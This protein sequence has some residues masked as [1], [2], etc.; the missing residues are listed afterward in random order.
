MLAIDEDATG[1]EQ[2][3]NRVG[4]GVCAVSPEGRVLFWNRAAERILGYAGRE[5][6]GRPC[7]DVFAGHDEHGNRICHAGCHVMTLVRMQEPVQHFDMLTRARDGRA[8]WLDVSIVALPQATAGHAVAGG[9]VLLHIFR[10][11]TAARELLDVVRARHGQ[12]SLDAPSGTAAPLTRREI[13]ILRLVAQGAPTK[14][15]AEKLHVSPAT[16]RN[17]VQNIL[18][19]LGAHNRLEAVAYATRHRL[20]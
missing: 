10:D 19:K 8:V 1:L 5:V 6:T 14:T 12:P 20:L 17:H 2:A 15:V 13:E 7:C 18:G 11:V 4:D 16:V 9:F 3:L